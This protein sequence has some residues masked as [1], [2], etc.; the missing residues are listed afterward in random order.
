MKKLR[1]TALLL[2]LAFCLTLPALAAEDEPTR[3]ASVDDLSLLRQYSY[4]SFVLAA[5]LDMSGVDWEPLPFS[6]TLDGAGHT[7]YNLSVNRPGAERLNTFDGNDRAYPTALAGLFSSLTDA[8]VRN[9]NLLGVDV[10]IDTAEHCFAAPLAGYM[11][12]TLVENCAVSDARVYLTLRCQEGL[13][14]AAI[15][16]TARWV[17]SWISTREAPPRSA[18]LRT[19]ARS[20]E[21]PTPGSV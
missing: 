18:A 21:N 10:D 2:C 6:G 16:C 1:L 14:A 8:Q 9:L 13:P 7:I 12:N 20:M 19:M 3:I 5:D 4:G 17:I 11:K 15:C